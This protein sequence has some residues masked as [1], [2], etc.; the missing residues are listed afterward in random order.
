MIEKLFATDGPIARAI[1]GYR[2][3]EGQ[4]QMAKTINDNQ[5]LQILEAG[6]GIGKTF[7]YLAPIIHNGLS[8]VI[9]TGTRA[10]QDQLF[11]RDIPLLQQALNR[12]VNVTMLKGRSNYLCRRNIENPTQ[13]GLYSHNTDDWE[14]LLYF[15]KNDKIGDISAIPDI[16]PHSSVWSAAVSTRDTCPASACKF[17][18]QCFLYKARTRAKSADIVVINHYLLMSDMHLREEQ[19]T[20]LIPARDIMVIDEAHLLPDLASS[21][22]GESLSTADIFRILADAQRYIDH[23]VIPRTLTPIVKH[24]RAALDSLLEAS[25]QLSESYIARD[26]LANKQWMNAATS[27][28]AAAHRM[29][30]HTIE[31]IA[32]SDAEC[33][34]WLTSIATRSSAIAQKLENWLDNDNNDILSAN[35]NTPPPSESESQEADKE[36][37]P[38][39]RWL[40]ANEQ[41]NTLTLFSA[42]VSGRDYFRRFWNDCRQVV[43]TS[44]TLSVNNSF[45]NFAEEIGM[46]NVHTHSWDSPFPYKKQALCYLPPM[47]A[48]PND[49]DYSEAVIRAAAP[50][51]TANQ[52]NAFMLFSSLRA[53]NEGAKML[54]DLFGDKYLVLKQ[55]DAPSDSLL[56]TFR[57]T[58]HSILAG[59]LSFWQGV[60]VKG[61]AL[62]LVIVDKI[63]FAPPDGILLKARDLWRQKRQENPFMYNQIPPA[64]ILMKQVAGRLIR[65]FNDRGVFMACDPRLYTKSYGKIILNSLPPM[66]Q[67][68]TE[69]TAVNFLKAIRK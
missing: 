16:S 25:S 22:F 35:D 7:A 53:L 55:G 62:S 44:A 69:K 19:I 27:L 13:S 6:T 10:L 54:A 2:P 68:T 12:S 63:P 8:A 43:A 37:I 14:R 26:I 66:K 56:K 51:I 57:A 17:Y 34:E 28:L 52:G 1:D 49:S 21:H 42:P 40:Q 45:D 59:S 33:G 38:I 23:S 18:D 29:R 41:K 61:D 39:V 20:E 50:L 30:E 31:H 24:W 9:S 32:D 60:D 67:T 11:L 65:D 58:P 15:A 3:R 36:E 4:I 47:D 5:G 48:A 64:T 46:E